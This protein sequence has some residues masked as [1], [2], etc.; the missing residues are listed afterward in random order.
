MM[1]VVNYT[2]CYLVLHVTDT[3]SMDDG[4]Q[5]LEELQGTKTSTWELSVSDHHI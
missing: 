4:K 1:N 2:A 5:G 3:T